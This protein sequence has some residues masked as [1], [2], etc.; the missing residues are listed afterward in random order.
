MEIKCGDQ[1]WHVQLMGK[2]EHLLIALHGY[3][4]S[5]AVFNHIAEL[6][7]EQY[8][9]LGI[10]LAFHGDQT[11][12]QTGFLFNREYASGWL[13]AI[14]S[15]TGKKSIGIMGYSIGGR[16]AIS[17][18]S[19]FPDKISELWLIAPDGLPV[20]KSYQ[21][22]TG[23]WLGVFIFKRFVE[24]PGIT[25][26]ILNAFEKLKFMQKKVIDFYLAQIQSLTKRKQLFDTWMAYREL[27]P[28]RRNLYKLSRSGKLPV[29]CILGKFDVVI[30]PKKTRRALVKTLPN[31]Q[32]IELEIGHNLLS[33]KAMRKLSEY[34]RE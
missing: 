8:T 4:Q 20:S 25:F 23:N 1:Y 14:L 16:I 3:G 7:E 27:I 9:L 34:W 5:S 32:I 13:D 31:A 30:R 6:L 26:A 33:E 2:G 24:S 11:D 12:F 29:T 10:D 17:L 28:N 18:A 15:Q 19:W 21:L 22:L